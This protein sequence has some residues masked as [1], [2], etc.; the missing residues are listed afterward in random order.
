[1][2]REAAVADVT[3]EEVA[4]AVDDPA[5]IDGIH[6]VEVA[7]TA[8]V[9]PDDPPIT[10]IEMEGL[11]RHPRPFTTNHRWVARDVDGRIVGHAVLNHG[12]TDENPTLASFDVVVHPDVRRRGIGRGFLASMVPRAREQQRTLLKSYA[13][14]GQPGER[15]LGA[16][17]AEERLVN[18]HS[19]L[20]IDD[21]DRSLLEGWVEKAQDRAADYDLLT[22]TGRTPDEHL[23]PMAG[24]LDVM[25]TAPR[26]DLEV[27]DEKTTPEHVRMWDARAEANG[28]VPYTVVA[29]HRPT[30]EFAGFT[31]IGVSTHRPQLAEQWGTGVWPHHR[32]RGLGRWVKAVNLL[33]VLDEAPD[34]R[35][36]DTDNAG[37]NEPMLNINVAMG[38]RPLLHLGDWQVPLDVLARHVGV[39]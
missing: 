37:T 17:G 33:R 38:F 2:T 26:G 16:L 13:V 21:V 36:V 8:E 18:R 35:T 14:K 12:T 28:M 29:R 1:M 23:E 10:R 34:V 9:L 19:R 3:I 30:G 11:L 15:F 20:R 4:G 27:E 24:L 32:E 25:N 5:V 6:E 7:V 39:G 31:M 22:W